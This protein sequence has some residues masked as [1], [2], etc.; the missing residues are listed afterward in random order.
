MAYLIWTFFPLVG[1][2]GGYFLAVII[3]L[4]AFP[5]SNLGPLPFIFT[6]WPVTFAGS[7]VLAI[8]LGLK[9]WRKEKVS[10]EKSS[11]N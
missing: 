9:A 6:V 7:I 2:V 4:A 3:G 8:W 11:N 10:A 1:L 5:D